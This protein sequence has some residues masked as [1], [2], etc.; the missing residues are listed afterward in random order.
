MRVWCDIMSY[1]KWRENL[2]GP[3]HAEYTKV[4]Y[5]VASVLARKRHTADDLLTHIGTVIMVY[6]DLPKDD[7]ARFGLRKD[8][9][10]M[11]AADCENF[12]QRYCSGRTHQELKATGGLE[13]R[14]SSLGRR[15]ARKAG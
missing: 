2:F 12:L 13:A 5:R 8:Y 10:K 11:I 4:K 3:L 6:H 14:L 1:K 15:A 7:L 9:L